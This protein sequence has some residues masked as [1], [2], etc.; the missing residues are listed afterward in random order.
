MP[1]S[2]V[3]IG[4]SGLTVFQWTGASTGPEGIMA[5]L[6]TIQDTA[7]TPVAQAV[8][9][10]SITDKTPK[11]IVTARAVGAGTLRLT[12]YELWNQ[13]VWEG[14]PNFSGAHSLL[15]VLTR[16]LSLGS[17]TCRKIIRKPDG[18]FRTKLYNN[19]VIVDVD[20]GEQVNIGTMV[21]PK[22]LTIMYTD[23]RM[24]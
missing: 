24:V 19:C 21:M 23:Y 4:G 6:Q 17:I 16:Q 3:R 2:K 9:V 20:D 14:L 15:D 7:P 13:S 12:F 22:G 18:S 1:Q 8:P 10:Q 5:Y 11:E